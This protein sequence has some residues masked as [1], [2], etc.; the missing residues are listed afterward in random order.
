MT[1]KPN[2]LVAVTMGKKKMS[3]RGGWAGGLGLQRQAY[4]E[5]TSS[6]KLAAA[7]DYVIGIDLK[8]ADKQF[9][10]QDIRHAR[11][12]ARSGASA[13]M[14]D[15]DFKDQNL[16]RYKKLLSDKWGDPAKINGLMK[17]MTAISNK[18]YQNALEKAM[19]TGDLPKQ[20][21]RYSSTA[22]SIAQLM[23]RVWSYYEDYLKYLKTAEKERETGGDRSG[24]YYETEAKNYALQLKKYYNQLVKYK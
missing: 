11:S 18:L 24:G 22:R 4:D 14:S 23:D 10:T 17:K 1:V 3:K 15:R 20:D 21:D 5:L 2:K 6:K 9:G 12:R 7:S 8:A 19:G 13:L 16:A